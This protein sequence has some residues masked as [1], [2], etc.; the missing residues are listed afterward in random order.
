MTAATN[1]FL[2]YQRSDG[3][4][5]S[6]GGGGTTYPKSQPGDPGKYSNLLKKPFLIGLRYWEVRDRFEELRSIDYGTHCNSLRN[7]Q[8]SNT[9]SSVCCIHYY[10]IGILCRISQVIVGESEVENREF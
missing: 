2:S 8:I 1:S 3:T 7:M 6:E 4:V 10:L 5:S 9:A